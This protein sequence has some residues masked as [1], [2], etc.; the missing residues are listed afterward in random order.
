[1]RRFEYLDDYLIKDDDTIQRI[2]SKYYLKW[3]L[4]PAIHHENLNVLGDNPYAPSQGK[5]VKIPY[6]NTSEILHTV[7]KGDIW[8]SLAE[9]Y[10]GSPVLF[11]H[12]AVSNES[13]LLAIGAQIKIPPLVTKRDIMT[14]KELRN[15]LSRS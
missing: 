3:W 12:I 10:Y 2:A 15:A 4:Y 14:A 7:V 6:L 8:Q 5:V 13:R 9:E 1:M 11:P